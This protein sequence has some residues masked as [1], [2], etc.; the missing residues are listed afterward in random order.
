MANNSSS[1]SKPSSSSFPVLI[2]YVIVALFLLFL[3][4]FSPA[5]PARPSRRLKLRSN[6]S[7]PAQTGQEDHHQFA[8]DPIIAEIQRKR[9]D[10]EW[11]KAHAAEVGVDHAPAM[12]GQPEWEGYMDAED[13]I[14]TDNRFNVTKRVELLFPKID[15]DP[16]DG[17]ITLEEL[18]NW[19]L[20]QARQE[21][22]HRS[23][24]DMD[25]HDK[26]KDG[27]VSFEEYER[28]SWSWRFDEE[29]ATNDGMGW[30]REKHFNAADLDSDGLLNLIEF[31]DFLHPADST[32][33]NLVNWLCK[34]E[35]RERD[36]DKDGL[37]SFKEY[38]GGLFY[39]IRN[40]DDF[41]S[42]SNSHEENY[43]ETTAKRLFDQI[44]KNNDGF[45]SA[46]ELLPF[47]HNLH[48]SEKFYAKQQANYLLGQADDDKDG[49]LSM[50]E[51]ID[52]PY[53]FYS[54]I[55]TEEDYK[56]HDEFR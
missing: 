6:F 33:P 2:I 55:F 23:K 30:W 14:N 10:R 3:L 42:D 17:L 44:D 25:L 35:I 50:K 47:I 13:Y 12:E 1:T 36:K 41:S 53:V 43:G 20:N 21:T 38:S 18:T 31:N 11:E 7:L 15:A 19:N 51:M 26:N 40:H 54:S 56:L 27:F 4:A 46:E 16:A 5:K 22:M 48:P 9:E 28:P 49:K 29:N 32:N 34:E 24:R 8:F 52:N 45:M 39:L 37:L